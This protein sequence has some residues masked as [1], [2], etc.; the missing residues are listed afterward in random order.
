MADSNYPVTV[1]K[2]YDD[3]RMHFAREY[4]CP[5][6]HATPEI[7][8]GRNL[9]GTGNVARLYMLHM[10]WCRLWEQLEDDFPVLVASI[11]ANMG[12]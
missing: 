7:H 2:N 12:V 11:K 9:D 3:P 1:T 10:G 4:A 8:L 6:C 5:D